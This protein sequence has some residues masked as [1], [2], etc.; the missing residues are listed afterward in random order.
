MAN[1]KHLNNAIR[2]VL[3]GK[4]RLIDFM[5]AGTE[6]C[7]ELEAYYELEGSINSEIYKLQVRKAK[8]VF[9]SGY[10][11]LRKIYYRV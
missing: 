6:A 8:R 5:D 10:K 11:S 9:D 2:D 7:E 4:L 3:E 1:N